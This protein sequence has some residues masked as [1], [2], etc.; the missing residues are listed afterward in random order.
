MRH[1]SEVSDDARA[2]GAVNCVHNKGGFLHG[3]NTD[4]TGAVKALGEVSGR[5]VV[6]LGAGGASRAIVYGLKKEGA[7]VIIQNRDMDKARA[8]AEEFGVSAQEG[9]SGDILVQATSIWTLEPTAELKDLVSEEFVSG[10]DTVM[11]IV[12]KPL[13]TPLLKVAEKMGKKVITGD[14]MLLFQAVEQFKI[15]TGKEAPVE[16][17]REALE[18]NLV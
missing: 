13:M 16:E 8:L 9:A 15:W 6:V 5:R 2:I 11:D 14:K 3:Y 17:M 10:F 18:R 1:L 12:Y 7:E 4:W